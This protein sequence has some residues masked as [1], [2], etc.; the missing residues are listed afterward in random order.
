M[1]HYKIS[2]VN[3][4]RFI[5]DFEECKKCML[6]LCPFI[7]PISCSSNFFEL[8]ILP[9]DCLVYRTDLDLGYAKTGKT[10]PQ[11]ETESNWK[12][13]PEAYTFELR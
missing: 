12:T 7:G 9:N 3:A 1:N 4:L 13:W 11:P 10:A 8:W 5:A 2:F 6:Y